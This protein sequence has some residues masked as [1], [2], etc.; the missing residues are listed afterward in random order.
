M[1]NRL[2]LAALALTLLAGVAAAEPPAAPAA[3]GQTRIARWQDDR[4][5]CF[6]LMFDDSWPSAFQVAAPELVKR[7]MIATFYICPAKGEYKK[8]A[9]TWEKE[10]WRQGMVY[11]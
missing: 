8:F 3:V 1:K 4:T 9:D 6:L 2:P 7:G 11:G 5:A 10:L